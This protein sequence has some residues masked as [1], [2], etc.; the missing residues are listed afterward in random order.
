MIGVGQMDRKVELYIRSESVDSNYGGIVD[1]TYAA[2][3][4]VVWSHIIWKGGKV[5]EK[6]EQMQNNEVVEFYCR[7]S[8]VMADANIE[9]YIAYDSKKYYIDVIN[10][11]DGREAYLQIITPTVTK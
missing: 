3:S 2:S 5:N 9:D 6:G 11:I 1:V 8:G 4:E 10:Q 7:N